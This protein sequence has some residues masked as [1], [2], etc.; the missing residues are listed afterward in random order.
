MVEASG[1]GTKELILEAAR[2]RFSEHGFSST[3]LNEIAD[4]VG[5]RRQ[6]LLHHFPSKEALY[7][8]VLMADLADWGT[9]VQ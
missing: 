7:Q 8:E 6:S 2:R 5:I 4:D 9:L 3:S 1:A